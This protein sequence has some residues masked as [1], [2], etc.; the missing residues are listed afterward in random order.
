[1]QQLTQKQLDEALSLVSEFFR[2]TSRPECSNWDALLRIYTEE[3]NKRHEL[4]GIAQF[5]A[6][7]TLTDEY[8]TDVMSV[9]QG[10]SLD[11]LTINAPHGHD[12]LANIPFSRCSMRHTKLSGANFLFCDIES[13]DLEGADISGAVFDGCTFIM[14]N[15][16][17][18]KL[19]N[20]E[21]KDLQGVGSVLDCCDL[22][23]STLIGAE[24]DGV[25]LNRVDFSLANFDRATI[26]DCHL[27]QCD[28]SRAALSDCKKF[29]ASTEGCHE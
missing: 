25:N 10:V 29:D 21:F 20:S 22:S 13:C 5:E 28:L 16:R 3:L 12:R 14:S 9:I 17:R 26:T 7:T 11:G 4:R 15:F 23:M 18:C 1:M 2:R 6:L 19:T 24:F 27:S 8:D